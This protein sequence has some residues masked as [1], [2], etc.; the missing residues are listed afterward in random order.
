MPELKKRP[1]GTSRENAPIAW[2]IQQTGSY[3]LGE[4][5]NGG[6]Y[7]DCIQMA[8]GMA[9]Q[10][11]PALTAI[12]AARG[13]PAVDLE[14]MIARLED[15]SRWASDAREEDYHTVNTHVFVTLWAAQEA[16]VEN[17]VSEIVR[18]DRGAAEVATGK[19]RAGRFPLDAWPWPETTCL[20]LAQRLEAKAKDATPNGGV[21]V[22]ARL[23]TLFSWFQLSVHIDADH[24]STY[25]EASMVRNVILHRYGRLGPKDIESFPRLA[26]WRDEVLP[27]TTARLRSYYQAVV[28]LHLAVTRAVFSSRYK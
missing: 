19:L 3:F 8:E 12:H 20:E 27:I 7:R 5:F 17:L 10:H 9:S 1:L 4:L 13:S 25:N 23:A 21:D 26:P 15:V 16:G 24:A 28:T 22:A 6:Y 11:R 14:R 18:T 2:V